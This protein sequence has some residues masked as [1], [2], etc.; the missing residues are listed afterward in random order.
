MKASAISSFAFLLL[1]CSM[2]T[3]CRAPHPQ[4]LP[5]PTAHVRVFVGG[6]IAKPGLHILPNRINSVPAFIESVGGPDT[7]A[8]FC[9]QKFYVMIVQP[10]PDAPEVTYHRK[11]W[12]SRRWRGVE[13][14]DGA[15]VFFR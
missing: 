12:L 15:D 2:V 7:N 4:P 8:C 6:Y 3:S 9:K 11:H 14:K 10:A 5:E 13:L 1:C